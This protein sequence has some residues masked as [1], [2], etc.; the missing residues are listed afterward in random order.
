MMPTTPTPPE[1]TTPTDQAPRL[2]CPAPADFRAEVAKYDAHAQVET[3]DGPRYRMT[4]R[5]LGEGPPLIVSPGIASTY[6][7]YALMLNGLAPRF[8]TILYDYPGDNS[9]DGA[10]IG[11][12]SHDDYVDDVFGLIDHL[13]IGRTFLF[14][15]S[16][17]STVV[18]KALHRE[19]RRFLRAAIQGA[20]AHRPLAF[21]ERL[22]LRVG[23]RIPGHSSRLPFHHRALSWN[24]RM[25]FPTIIEDRWDYYVAQN[26]MTPIAPMAARLDLLGRLDLRP[27]L[28]EIPTEVLVLQ[29]NED[30][31][32]RRR[33]YEELL[34]GLPNA[35]GVL[36]PMV[37][38]QPH[39][40]HAEGMASALDE[41]FLPC[42]PGGCPSERPDGEEVTS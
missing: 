34:A 38:H 29:G 41:F 19:P 2:P 27:I 10:R 12:L 8:Q 14:G 17:G 3:W 23:R 13:N 25:H 28:P 24:N 22:A 7:G 32:V 18:L 1:T 37:G 21:A 4:Y 16:F 9:K 39:Y 20:F 42:A 40:T 36:M 15:P 31:I 35:R 6:R 26:G 5:V 11:R 30:R 33:H